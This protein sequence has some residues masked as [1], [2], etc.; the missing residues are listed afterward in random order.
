MED[1]RH[2]LVE[3]RRQRPPAVDVHALRV[4]GRQLNRRQRV[5]D[6]VRDLAR[7][8]GPR[9][10]PLRALE[11]GALALQV[12]RHAVEVL[13]QPAQF[14][15]GRRGDPRVEIAARD[16]ARGAREPVDRIGDALG[17]P[18]AHGGAE[19]HHEHRAEDHLPVELVDLAIELLLAE[20]QRHDDDAVAASGAHR[21]RRDAVREV[22][23]LLDADEHRQP[24]EDH[25]PVRRARRAHRQQARREQIALARRFEPRTIEEVDVLVDGAADEHH[26]LVV[27]RGER[28]GPRCCSVA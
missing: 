17:H 10:E 14:V 9:F 6:V 21:R 23:D 19:Q 2:A 11:L 28:A 3:H 8:V 15:G 20:R 18:V 1:R 25:V 13:D 26:D 5:L 24:V 22:G 27:D 12:R 7:H 16:A 4:L